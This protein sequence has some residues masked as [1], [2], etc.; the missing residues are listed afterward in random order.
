MERLIK[1]IKLNN[2]QYNSNRDPQFYRRTVGSEFRVQAWLEG[3][4]TARVHLQAGDE[5]LCERS[6]PLPGV[7]E[8]R[9]TFTTPG[10]RVGTLTVEANGVRQQQH[11]RLDVE[12]HAWE[13]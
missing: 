3:S 8:C 11:I 12:A 1:L 13:G 5:T 9:F 4:G 6:M 10:T 2:V 7:F